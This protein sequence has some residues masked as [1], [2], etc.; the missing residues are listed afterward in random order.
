MVLVDLI[1]IECSLGCVISSSD[2]RIF[3][4]F[5][6]DWSY[7]PQKTY[8]LPQVSYPESKSLATSVVGAELSKKTEGST[9]SYIQSLNFAVFGMVLS[10]RMCG[11]SSRDPVLPTA[12]KTSKGLSVQRRDCWTA[13]CP[14]FWSSFSLKDVLKQHSCVESL[15]LLLLLERLIPP[16]PEPLGEEY[17]GIH[18]T[19]SQLSPVADYSAFLDP[20]RCLPVISLFSNF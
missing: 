11:A 18:I 8:G 15:P 17:C 9:H 13:S 6:L 2:V 19:A 1:T 3:G 12:E 14:A 16:S 7:F 10:H 5:P 4:S 20:L